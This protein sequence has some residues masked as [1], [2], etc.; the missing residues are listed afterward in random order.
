LKEGKTVYFR[1]SRNFLPTDAGRLQDV[2]QQTGSEG[3]R[4]VDGNR[5]GVAEI[6]MRHEVMAALDAV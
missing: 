2:E 6:R 1:S 3:L 4:A 5:D